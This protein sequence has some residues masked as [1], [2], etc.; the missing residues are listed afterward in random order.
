MTPQ[1]KATAAGLTA[2]VVTPRPMAVAQ[3]SVMDRLF[4]A[5]MRKKRLSKQK[6]TSLIDDF[7]VFFY[8]LITFLFNL[9]RLV[10]FGKKITVGIE[11]PD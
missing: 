8:S 10:L 3:S 9:A 1:K 2:A 6:V 11:I 4:I 7:I 5:V